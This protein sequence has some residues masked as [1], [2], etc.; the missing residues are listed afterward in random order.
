MTTEATIAGRPIHGKISHYGSEPSHQKPLSEFL[1]ALDALLAFPEVEAVRWHQY[2]PYFNDGEACEFSIYEAHVK[3][4][5][6]DDSGES[7]DGFRDASGVYPPGY[8]ETHERKHSTSQWNGVTRRYDY[9]VVAG[10]PNKAEAS[11][12]DLD[13]Y[14][15]GVLRKDIEAAHEAFNNAVGSGAHYV[16]L[17]K[18]FGDPAEVTAT[19][20]GFD[21]EFYDHD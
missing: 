21:V 2:T 15:N 17:R 16:D 11:Y 1:E 13:Y 8:W 5:G 4:A 19:R 12:K 9:V 6:D 14:V 20:E 18:H 3:F 7:E 10:D